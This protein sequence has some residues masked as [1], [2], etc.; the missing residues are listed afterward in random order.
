MFAAHCGDWFFGGPGG[1]GDRRGRSWG[2][3]DFLGGFWWGGPGPR[4]RRRGPGR[5]FEQGDLRFV[6]LRSSIEAPPGTRSQGLE[7]RFRWRITQPGTSTL[8]HD[9]GDL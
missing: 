2:F 1:P 9:A 7:D 6:I 4:G 5:M 3:E 8:P